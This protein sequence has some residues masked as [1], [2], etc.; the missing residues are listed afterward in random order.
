MEIL[1]HLTYSPWKSRAYTQETSPRQPVEPVRAFCDCRKQVE[2][3]RCQIRWIG[4]AW[5]AA[6]A[7]FF[8]STCRSET[9]VNRAMVEMNYGSFFMRRPS[10]RKDR[11]FARN[12]HACHR[13]GAIH[14]NIIWESVENREAVRISYDCKDEFVARNVKSSLCDHI[15]SRQSPHATWL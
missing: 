12:E 10:S 15:I 6:N 1:F 9:F 2:I 14:F 3:T 13:R 4:L 5:R 11:L 8:R 7:A